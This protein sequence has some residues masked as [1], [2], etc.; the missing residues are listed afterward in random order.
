M[1]NTKTHH[2]QI[3]FT[4]NLLV[5]SLILF[6]CLTSLAQAQTL[7][8]RQ[9]GIGQPGQADIGD[10]FGQS[11]TPPTLQV[12]I[13]RLIRIFLSLIGVIFLILLVVAGVRWMTS[14]GNEQ[15]VTSAKSQIIAAVIGLIIIMMAYSITSYVTSCVYDLNKN[16]AAIWNCKP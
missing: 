8:D 1:K 3:L 14:G 11:G 5:M 2:K 6:S 4:V 7:Y 13:S 16:A 15:T 12:I 10:A 9:Y